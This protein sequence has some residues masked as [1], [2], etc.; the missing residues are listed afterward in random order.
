MSKNKL[1][2]LAYR[3]TQ[4]KETEPP[5]SQHGFDGSNGI[6]KCVCCENP[7]FNSKTKYESGSGWPSFYEPHKASSIETASDNSH[8][9]RRT[10]VHCKDCGAHLGHVFEDGPL[11]SGLRYCINGVALSFEKS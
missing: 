11:P 1:T 5:F 4:L 3:V 9:M 2:E 8:G 7:L 6:Y 10:E